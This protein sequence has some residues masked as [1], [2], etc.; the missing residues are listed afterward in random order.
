[1]RL[2][3]VANTT[4]SS[5]TARMRVVIQKALSADHEVRFVETSRPG[6]AERLARAAARTGIDA[7]V[8]LSGDGTLNEAAGGL[9]GTDTAIAPLPGGST[10]VYARTL[11]YARDPVEATRQLLRALEQRSFR[12]T[13]VGRA[14]G[15]IFLFTMGVGFDAEVVHQAERRSAFKR[16]VA[17]PLYALSAFDTW[18]RLYDRHHERFRIEL[19]DR[20][21][22][23]GCFFAIVSKT[24]PYTFLG[25]YPF[26]VAPEAD[27]DSRLVLDAYQVQSAGSFLA[28]AASSLAS[29][30]YYRRSRKVFH[31]PDLDHLVI[32]GEKPFPWQVDGEYLGETTHV[33]VSYQPDALTVVEAG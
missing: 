20:R 16:F 14:N 30:R 28:L 15:R 10:N 33:E 32:A 25:P 3:L 9:V 6:H 31:E 17:H 19:P 22:V 21:I 26:R 5:F 23:G 1:M 7:V 2:V 8:V 4:A 12:R 29:G 11:G 13:G 18:F 24:S 27:L